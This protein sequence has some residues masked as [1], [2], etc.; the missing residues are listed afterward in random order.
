MKKIL[1]SIGIVFFIGLIISLNSCSKDST[2]LN[3]PSMKATV[4]GAEWTSIFR[5]SVL[6]QNQSPANIVITGTPTLSQTADKTIIL[7]IK[8]TDAGTYTLGLGSATAQCLV[9]YKK[10]S[11]AAANSGNY[12][13][14]T[15]A[16][17]TISK[18]DKEKKQMSGTFSAKLY[19]IGVATPV[20]ITNGI[21]ENLN[22][23]LN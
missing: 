6:N 5:L 8:G 23:Q 19:A 2:I 3:L 17:I 18:L 7:T 22:Y 20:V 1:Q 21:F 11:D 4:D 12:F 15:E 10:T 9:V 13:T 14:S 16:T